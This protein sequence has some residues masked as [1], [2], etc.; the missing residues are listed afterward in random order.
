MTMKPYGTRPLLALFALMLCIGFTRPA[1]AATQQGADRPAGCYAHLA[2]PEIKASY[3]EYYWFDGV[4]HARVALTMANSADFPDELF[5]PSPEL[6]PCGLNDRA[7]RTWAAVFD[8]QGNRIGGFCAMTH[9]GQLDHL[10]FALE[11]DRMPDGVYVTLEDRLCG[12]VFTSNVA[13]LSDDVDGDA[14]PNRHDNCTVVANADQ[15]DTDNDGIG[16]ACDA[17]LNN[18]CTLSFHDLALF[19]AAFFSSDP[20]ADLNGDG[21]VN[22]GDLAIARANFF[23]EPGPAGPDGLCIQ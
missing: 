8:S 18:D 12:T 14:V 13:M 20:D 21:V 5:A 16:N 10:W 4:L 17:D 22:F 3:P 6:P 2:A 7:S 15:R 23:S 11:E 1:V 9:N 19:R